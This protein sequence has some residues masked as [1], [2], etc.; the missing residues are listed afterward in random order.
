MKKFLLPLL[1]LTSMVTAG[2][3]A[4]VLNPI[5]VRTKPLPVQNEQLTMISTP[6][7]APVLPQAIPSR[8]ETYMFVGNAGAPKSALRGGDDP[9]SL[10][11]AVCLSSANRTKFAGNSI[12]GVRY[13]HGPI[14]K[15]SDP[16]V[17]MFITEDLYGE[18]LVEQ[19]TT[20]TEFGTFAYVDVAFAEPFTI[21]PGDDD[22]YIGWRGTFKQSDG[23]YPLAIDYLDMDLDE[24]MSDYVGLVQDGEWNWNRFGVYYGNACVWAVVGG[25]NLPVNDMGVYAV[26]VPAAIQQ[27]KTFDCKFSVANEASNGV[28]SATVVYTV[29]NSEPQS[30]DITFDTPLEYNHIAEVTI[31]MTCDEQGVAI[32]VMVTIVKVNGEDDTNGSNNTAYAQT[33]CMSPDLGFERRVLIEEGTGTWCGWCVRG[34]VALDQMKKKYGADGRL[35]EIGVHSGDDMEISEYKG[36]LARYF[37]GFP[38]GMIDR[39]V[40]SDMYLDNVEATYLQQIE[41]PTPVG[42]ICEAVVSPKQDEVEI[43][44]TAQF[45]LDEKGANF[46]VASV[47][48]E[49]KVGPYTQANYYSGGAYG[50]MGGYEKRAKTVSMRFSDVAVAATEM[51]GTAGAFP[52]TVES[53]KSYTYSQTVSLGNVKK[54]DNCRFVTMVINKATGAVMNVAETDAKSGIGV[55]AD[56]ADAPVELFTIQ[57]VRVNPETVLPGLYIRRQGNN[58]SKIQIR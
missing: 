23:T 36:F 11:A 9:Y 25:D 29:G 26:K 18:S 46:L 6:A 20:I 48:V 14:D 50:E 33:C 43:T 5:Q 39:T 41:S 15:A 10:G 12:V 17:T 53:G 34:I 35:V 49:D 32:P 3:Q 45:A 38:S 44:G 21:T 56:D 7:Q 8:G 24:Y 37:S 28:T 13:A 16:E 51:L 1:V 22:L 57:G 27:G 30:Y 55:V 4:E 52:E 54:L 47:V 42:L 2:V 19:A 31:P 58:V 40:L